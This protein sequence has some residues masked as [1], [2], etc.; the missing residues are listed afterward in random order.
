VWIDAEIKNGDRIDRIKMRIPRFLT[1][2]TIIYAK[3]HIEHAAKKVPPEFL[4]CVSGPDVAEALTASAPDGRKFN[5]QNV[6]DL[7]KALIKRFRAA[8]RKAGHTFI[9]PGLF[10]HEP[11]VGTRLSAPEVEIREIVDPPQVQDDAAP[12]SCGNAG[13]SSPKKD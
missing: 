12:D 6:A 9:A 1:A 2:V 4:G 13:P 7:R 3:A 11:E 8:V 5:W 10:E